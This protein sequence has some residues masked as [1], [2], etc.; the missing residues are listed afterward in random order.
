MVFGAFPELH[1]ASGALEQLERDGFK[2]A[3]FSAIGPQT[4]R[5]DRGDT[6][7]LLGEL[8][9]R[10]V[11]AP[12]LAVSGRDVASAGALP[13][14]LEPGAS[15]AVG[16]LRASFENAGVSSDTA[17]RFEGTVRDSGLI[18]GVATEDPERAQRARDILS[19]T[20]AVETAAFPK[21]T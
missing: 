10:M 11:H 2:A 18:L 8:L 16:G 9:S 7:G 6:K 13:G 5:G 20:G 3:G 12:S 4:E 1:K 17:R 15:A 14:L 21:G 19:Q